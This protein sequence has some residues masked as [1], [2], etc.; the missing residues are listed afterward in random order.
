M[1][2]L[3]FKIKKQL[4]ENVGLFNEINPFYVS[5]NMGRPSTPFFEDFVS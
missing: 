2:N 5:L 1:N 3:E 4:T